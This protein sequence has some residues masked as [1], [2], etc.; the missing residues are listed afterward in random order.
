MRR[1]GGRNPRA[2]KRDYNTKYQRRRDSNKEFLRISATVK[3]PLDI[4]C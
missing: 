1:T 4:H 3:E 2:K